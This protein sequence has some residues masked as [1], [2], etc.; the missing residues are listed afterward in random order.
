MRAATVALIAVLTLPT[1]M[2][3]QAP[4]GT[5]EFAVSGFILALNIPNHMVAN[6]DGTPLM[7]GPGFWL[8]IKNATAVPL[9][10]CK[11]GSGSAIISST[12]IGPGVYS[13]TAG[14]ARFRRLS[15][16]GIS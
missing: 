8:A 16:Q 12:V 11:F 1:A 15:R 5:E 9:S 2:K 4:V 3:A 14:R 13:S 7:S 10:L 6:G